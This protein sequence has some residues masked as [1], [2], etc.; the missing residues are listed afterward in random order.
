MRIPGDGSPTIRM[1]TEV[2]AETLSKDNFDVHNI[3]G[4]KTNKKQS[5]KCISGIDKK[6]ETCY[7]FENRT[8]S[9]FVL[10]EYAELKTEEMIQCEKVCK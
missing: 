9:V 8:H 5:V 6:K 2:D 7:Y 3:Y 10:A 1:D 4:I